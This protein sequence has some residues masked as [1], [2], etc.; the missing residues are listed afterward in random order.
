VF[1]VLNRQRLAT[2]PDGS[3]ARPFRFDGPAVPPKPWERGLKDTVAALPGY[4][5]RVKADFDT[6]GQY[7]WH[8]HILEHEDNEL[9]RPFLIC[10]VKPGQPRP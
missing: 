4:V 8:C 3:V 5:T 1:A 6:A 7:V 2:D 10:P 9:K